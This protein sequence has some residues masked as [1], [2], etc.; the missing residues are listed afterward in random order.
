MT[1]GT[2]V[3]SL[4][5]AVYLARRAHWG[6]WLR[7]KSAWYGRFSSGVHIGLAAALTAL[8][9]LMGWLT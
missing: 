5:A 1:G 3:L 7:E 9:S 6:G 8:V 2:A 4:I